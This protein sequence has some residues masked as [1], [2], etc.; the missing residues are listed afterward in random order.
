MPILFFFF[1]CAEKEGSIGPYG[2][3][4]ELL[5]LII[6]LILLFLRYVSEPRAHVRE[7]FS[8]VGLDAV[9]ASRG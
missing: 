1:P 4:L 2:G 7:L 3:V 9:L 6:V 8:L 5:L